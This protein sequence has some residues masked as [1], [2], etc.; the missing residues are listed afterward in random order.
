MAYGLLVMLA[1]MGEEGETQKLIDYCKDNGFIYSWQQLEVQED[2]A[3][4]VAKLADFAASD[5]ETF[6][7]AVP[8][9]TPEQVQAAVYQ[10]EAQ[11]K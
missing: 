7:L 6:K 8:G 11:A 9:V 5:K 4:A 3:T 1:A 2:M 10:V